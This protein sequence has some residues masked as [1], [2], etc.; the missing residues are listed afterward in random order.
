MEYREIMEAF[1]QYVKEEKP[2]VESPT[3]MARM[4]RP[5]FHGLRQE[6]FHVILL[7]A[8]N[9][10][11]KDV[12]VTRGLADRSMVHA[13]EV[14]REAIVANASRIVL[15]HNHPSGDLTP[16][17]NDIHTTGGLVEAG[18]IIGIE[19]IDHVIMG[20]RTG[21]REKDYLSFREENLI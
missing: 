11:V 21:Q 13:R 8:N 7:N 3:D 10:I 18:K 12:M 16:S 20:S 14:F 17:P 1:S 4:M 15:A 5:I 2:R 19:V 9:R 6:E